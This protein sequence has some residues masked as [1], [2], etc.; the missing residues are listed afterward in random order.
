M[1]SPRNSNRKLLRM[2]RD[3]S[4]Q[5][6]ST[7]S[8]RHADISSKISSGEQ[9]NPEKSNMHPLVKMFSGHTV[10][11]LRVL[12]TMTVVHGRR[13]YESREVVLAFPQSKFVLH[14]IVTC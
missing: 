2:K 12:V 10:S 9:S 6:R 1:S 8:V 5:P 7:W 14:G 4:H 11:F 3:G 13:V